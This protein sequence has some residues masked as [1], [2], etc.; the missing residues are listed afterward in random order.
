MNFQHI[1]FSFQQFW[2]ERGDLLFFMGFSLV[3]LLNLLRI[4]MRSVLPSEILTYA[5]FF[6]SLF[7]VVVFLF[8]VANYEKTKS[9]LVSYFFR[10]F[11]T[12]IVQNLLLFFLMFEQF[13]FFHIVSYIVLMFIIS[14]GLSVLLRSDSLFLSI[15]SQI[16]VVL[17]ALHLRLKDR[18]LNAP[19]LISV[20]IP[21]KDEPLRWE[22]VISGLDALLA[23][24]MEPLFSSP[25]S[26]LLFNGTTLSNRTSMYFPSIQNQLPH[27]N[28]VTFPFSFVAPGYRQKASTRA[29]VRN[30]FNWVATSMQQH[31]GGVS[32]ATAVGLGFGYAVMYDQQRFALEKQKHTDDM[33]IRKQ[34]LAQEMEMRKQALAQE[35]E[36]RNKEL[37]EKIG[38]RLK[39]AQ[40]ESKVALAQEETKIWL[41]EERVK[42]KYFEL[43]RIKQETV[44]F[45]AKKEQGIIDRQEKM[46][47]NSTTLF[48]SEHIPET[49]S[50]G[51]SNFAT[52]LSESKPPMIPAALVEN[53]SLLFYFFR[54]LKF[55]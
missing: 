4:T 42:E 23:K 19:A 54:L 18:V 27:R 38:N 48:P 9:S 37:H 17:A 1:K 35:M 41:A 26:I 46:Q 50:T 52:S 53:N 21:L 2:K 10:F 49:S 13:L 33:E 6:L 32:G 55:F 7:W 34:A 24:K 44:L 16:F 45:Q 22:T 14:C 3:P 20:G 43:E 11:N 12:K 40:E 36:M 29:A 5:L 28:Q 47:G 31:P 25:K 8:L 51:N 30:M 39:I 15:L